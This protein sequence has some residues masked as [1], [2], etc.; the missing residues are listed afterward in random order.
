MTNHFFGAIHFFATISL[1]ACSILLI[2]ISISGGIWRDFSLLTIDLKDN[3]AFEVIH[4]SRDRDSYASYGIFGY[5]IQNINLG[6]GYQKKACSDPTVGYPITEVQTAIDGTEFTD[7]DKKL[8]GL[9][10][11][12]ILHPIAAVTFFLACV[13]SIR[14]GYL[15]T[16]SSMVLT[17]I[18]WI[19]SGIAMAIDIYVFII[20]HERVASEEFG[21]GSRPIYG[22]ALWCLI[23]TFGLAT[24]AVLVTSVTL[25][26]GKYYWRG[27]KMEDRRTRKRGRIQ[28]G[29]DGE[30][31]SSDSSPVRRW[32]RDENPQPF[33]RHRTDRD[34]EALVFH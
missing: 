4:F 1:L 17:F 3:S 15:R 10:K 9:T 23:V 26:Q 7:G 20:V 34:Q 11:V 14:S 27:T 29:V 21:G 2:L 25:W 30:M 28:R 12:M 13:F 5:C 31:H 33:W 16:L 18:S 22:G 19:L 8:D 6:Q 24:F 32:A